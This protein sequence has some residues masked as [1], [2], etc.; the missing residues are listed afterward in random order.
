MKGGGSREQRV[1]NIHL[2]LDLELAERTTE[3]FKPDK[4]SERIC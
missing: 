1:E 3:E 4:D 2:Q